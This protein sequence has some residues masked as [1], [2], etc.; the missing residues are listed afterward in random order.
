[1]YGGLVLSRASLDAV[2]RHLLDADVDPEAD[3]DG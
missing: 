1:M 3:V 2:V